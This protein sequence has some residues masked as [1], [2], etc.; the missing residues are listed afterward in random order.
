MHYQEL[1]W[2]SMLLCSP[3]DMDCSTSAFIL[4]SF[5]TEWVHFG[6][7]L[8]EWSASSGLCSCRLESENYIIPVFLKK[9]NGKMGDC[10]PIESMCLNESDFGWSFTRF[11]AGNVNFNLLAV[12]WEDDVFNLQRSE[13]KLSS[14]WVI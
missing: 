3:W 10:H 9:E 11:C 7:F 12:L 14:L 6:G 1:S 5:W 13:E 2:D 4:H 8:C